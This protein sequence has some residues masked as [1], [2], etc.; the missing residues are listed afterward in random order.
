MNRLRSQAGISLIEVLVAVG[1]F[2]VAAAGLTTSAVSN[3]K[4]N[5]SSRTIA[6][7]TSLVQ[8]KI[9]QIRLTAPVG[10]V[11][12]P[13]LSLGSHTDASNPMTALGGPNGTFTRSWTVAGVPQYLAGSVVGVKPGMVQ[14]AVTVSWTS[15]SAGTL[16]G[17]TYACITSSCG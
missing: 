1:L 2:S 16:T 17:V 15:P 10:G 6:A 8:N 7:A 13:E 3:I 9:E 12:P 14:V 5:N 11:V 4:L